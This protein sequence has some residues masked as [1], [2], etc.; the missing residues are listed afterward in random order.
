MTLSSLHAAHE[1]SHN[2][3]GVCEGEQGDDGERQL[4]AHQDVEVVV[5]IGEI[6]HAGEECDKEGWQDGDGT[7]DEESLPTLP[8]Q[9]EETLHGELTGVGSS[10]GGGLTCSQETHCPDVESSYT[11][12][13]AQEN[14]LHIKKLKWK[15]L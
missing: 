1:G 7:S 12:L 11:E 5:H 4:D 9:V 3:V 2:G 10:H 14:T 15:I 8:A 6:R 13:A